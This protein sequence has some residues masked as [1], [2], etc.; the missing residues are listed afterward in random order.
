MPPRNQSAQRKQRAGVSGR[1]LGILVMLLIVPSIALGRLAVLIDW[2]VLAGVLLALSLFSFLS[3]RSDKRRAE[4]GEW[5]IPESA[6]HLTELLGGWPGAFLAQRIF[7][8]KIAKGS[9]QLI[10]WTVVLIHEFVAADFLLGWRFTRAVF[11]LIHS[12]TV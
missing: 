5:R 12:Q 9:Y 2:R 4:S 6:L 10:F 1:A 11:H 8:H 3:Y 7:R